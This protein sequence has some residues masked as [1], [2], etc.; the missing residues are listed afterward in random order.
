MTR[1]YR[2]TYALITGASQGLGKYLAIELSER[3]YNTIL[4]ALPKENIHEVA[5]LC[6]KNGTKSVIYEIDLTNKQNIL[7]LTHWVN[8]NYDLSILVN[9]AGLGGT[10]SFVDSDVDYIDNIIQLNIRA[11]TLITHQLLPNL[12]KQENGYIL[13]V[14]SM[15]SF[16]PIGYKTV[17]PASKKFVQSFTLG[18]NQELKN[19]N[20]FAS[21]VHPGP[22]KTNQSVTQRI[23]NQG[24]IGRLGLMSPE[25]VAKK[26]ICNLLK[27]KPLILLGWSNRINW[28][29]LVLTPRNIKLPL[30][31]RAVKR[32][33][34]A[35]KKTVK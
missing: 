28:L 2:D 4:V 15:A 35:A 18:L 16:S 9:N 29:L 27:K 8:D 22:M 12:L 19:S 32:E 14:S 23:E 24:W 30:L 26:A 17:Y 1:Q 7:Q 6:R 20:V 5:D 31:T 33:I 13:N 3:K 25:M 10:R 21:V 34:V 11:L